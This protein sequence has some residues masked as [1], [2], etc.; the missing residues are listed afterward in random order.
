MRPIDFNYRKSMRKYEARKAGIIKANRMAYYISRDYRG[1]NFS[2]SPLTY[3]PNN[4][5]LKEITLDY[6][7]GALYNIS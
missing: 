1:S 3:R 5:S 4:L 7:T 2:K 6:Y